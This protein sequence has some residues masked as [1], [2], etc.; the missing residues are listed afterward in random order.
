MKESSISE[1]VTKGAALH[2]L[3]DFIVLKIIESIHCSK[4]L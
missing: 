3:S 1:F 2:V 4:K